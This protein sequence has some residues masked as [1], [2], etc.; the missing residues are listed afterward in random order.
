[1][2]KLIK[3]E[4]RRILGRRGS[5]WG[6]AIVIGLFALGDVVWALV[7]SNPTA[8]T[9]IVDGGG[10]VAV[11]VILCSIILG[12]TAGSYDVDKGTMRYLVLTGVSRWKLALVRIPG[13]II[14]IV[15]VSFPGIA[16]VLLAGLIAGGGGATAGNVFDVFY[17]AWTGGIMYGL[18]SLAIGTFLKSNGV[19][20][21]VAILV[22]FIGAQISFLIA[23][24]V[25]EGLGHLF[26]STASEIVLDRDT[27]GPI[28]L[29]LAIAVLI[30]WLVVLLG[31]A[32]LRV[33]RAEY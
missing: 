3:A 13:L 25:S 30:T 2:I 18:L 32:T 7:A 21:A 12:A 10:L 11:I 27:A 31:A 24:H 9:A 33:Q 28:S 20:I 22:N 15:L 1:M 29:G 8:E 19:A 4:L 6:S 14:A 16:L 26:F 17:L 5:A 23:D